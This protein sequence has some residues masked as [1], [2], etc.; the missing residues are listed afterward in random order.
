MKSPLTHDQCLEWT[1]VKTF[2]PSPSFLPPVRTSGWLQATPTTWFLSCRPTRLS[3]PTRTTLRTR[4]EGAFTRTWISGSLK[5]HKH[6][7]CMN[8]FKEQAGTSVTWNPSWQ[9][10][11]RNSQCPFSWPTPFRPQGRCLISCL[12]SKN[13]RWLVWMP[14]LWVIASETTWGDV[15]DLSCGCTWITY[16]ILLLRKQECSKF[17]HNN[18]PV[19]RIVEHPFYCFS[20]CMWSQRYSQITTALRVKHGVWKTFPHIKQFILLLYFSI[21]GTKRDVCEA[22]Y[23]CYALVTKWV[24]NIRF[25]VSFIFIKKKIQLYF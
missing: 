6:K 7:M 10:V 9:S 15:D 18:Q 14:G 5:Y 4:Q 13:R 21:Y 3:D 12:C 19:P 11:T 1:T 25:A 8:L 22:W 17:F 23:T 20:L 16:L 24:L 2:S